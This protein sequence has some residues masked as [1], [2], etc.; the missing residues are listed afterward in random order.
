[1]LGGFTH[2][3]STQRLLP[4]VALVVAFAFPIADLFLNRPAQRMA[5]TSG[6]VLVTSNP[7]WPVH[8]WTIPGPR[9]DWGLIGFSQA[10]YRARSTEIRFGS[11]S[12]SFGFSIYAV[13]GFA[14]CA[15]LAAVGF[16]AVAFRRDHDNAA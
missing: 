5:L 13:A 10:P 15:F 4:V 6:P 16:A 11:S 12:L 8:T 9:G 7:S 3:M 2:A 1:M 14:A